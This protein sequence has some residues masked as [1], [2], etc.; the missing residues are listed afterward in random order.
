MGTERRDVKHKELIEARG[1]YGVTVA[2]QPPVCITCGRHVTPPA[3]TPALHGGR[4]AGLAAGA[5]K[6][7]RAARVYAPGGLA[8]PRCEEAG[9]SEAA[10]WGYTSERKGAEPGG[11]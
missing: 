10:C 2:S 9:A 8:G 7:D 11:R 3:L 4:R 1:G 6:L 5:F